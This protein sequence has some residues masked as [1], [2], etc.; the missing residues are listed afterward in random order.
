MDDVIP[1]KPNLSKANKEG[2]N[3]AKSNLIPQGGAIKPSIKEVM[4]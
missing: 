3:S 4:K 1:M 2:G